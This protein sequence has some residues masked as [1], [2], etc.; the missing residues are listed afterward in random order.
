[1]VLLWFFSLYTIIY[2]TYIGSS[3]HILLL[4][5]L[6][7][8]IK[9]TYNLHTPVTY[10][11]PFVITICIPDS[12]L[13][14]FLPPFLF[15]YMCGL[16]LFFSLYLVSY[17]HTYTVPSLPTPTHFIPFSKFP[18]PPAATLQTLFEHRFFAFCAL[19][20]F[21]CNKTYHLPSCWFY[22]CLRSAFGSSSFLLD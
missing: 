19:Q 13:I 14:P 18:P 4:H 20:F 15:L 5:F 8:N 17:I 16:P 11:F 22:C 2:S 6:H 9:T 21:A 3:I 12:S 10:L 1:M 7:K